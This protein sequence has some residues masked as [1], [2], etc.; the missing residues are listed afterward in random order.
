MLEISTTAT[1][2]AYMYHIDAPCAIVK[3]KRHTCQPL[4]YIETH[5]NRSDCIKTEVVPQGG[6]VQSAT[7]HVSGWSVRVPLHSRK[8]LHG[9]CILL[10]RFVH[11]GKS[12]PMLLPKTTLSSEDG[13]ALW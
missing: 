3:S 1:T 9:L 8:K 13:C 11:A 12:H 5:M 7:G 6:V 2:M 4:V 10:H